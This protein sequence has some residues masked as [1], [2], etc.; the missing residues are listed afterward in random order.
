MTGAG[1][2]SRM[3]LESELDGIRT[4]EELAITRGTY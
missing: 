4:E 2:W 1:G 3:L